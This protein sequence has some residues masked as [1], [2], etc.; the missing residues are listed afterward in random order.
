ME[1]KI[2]KPGNVTAGAVQVSDLTFAREFNEDLVH[3][4]VTAYLSAARQGS[5][6]QKT[7]SEVRGGG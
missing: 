6:Q 4:V 5:R 2:A 3:Q 7:R 1:L